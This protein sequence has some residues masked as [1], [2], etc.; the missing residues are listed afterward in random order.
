MSAQKADDGFDLA[1]VYDVTLDLY[2]VRLS[3][4][5]DL[6]L[7]RLVRLLPIICQASGTARDLSLQRKPCTPASSVVTVIVLSSAPRHL[8]S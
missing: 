3:E 5:A 1:T 8:A 6:L 2:A 4:G 7:Q